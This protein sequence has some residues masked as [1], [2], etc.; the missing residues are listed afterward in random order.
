MKN[1]YFKI[2]VLVLGTLL[3]IFLLWNFKSLLLP[4][5]ESENNNPLDKVNIYF[6]NVG[7]ADSI[8]IESYSGNILIDSG[9]N[10]DGDLLVRRLGD[11]GINKLDYLILTHPHKDHI[12]GAPK[13]LENITVD[14]IIKSDL[15][16]DSKPYNKLEEAILEKDIPNVV[17]KAS[18]K[19][20]LGE[21]EFKILFP[22]KKYYKEEN[23][24]SLVLEMKHGS[25]KFLFTGDI[26]EEGLE[27]L[28]LNKEIANY[29]LLKVPHHGGFEDLTSIFINT[30]KP[31]FAIITNDIEESKNP[32]SE[33]VLQLLKMNNTKTFITGKGE[34]KCISDGENFH[35]SQ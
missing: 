30:I 16:V 2:I 27:E 9:T 21:L 3:C 10:K 34:I 8:L 33:E 23:D 18:D 22:S 14:K 32:I 20:N 4:S 35:I 17:G 11:L 31:K 13:I 5:K 15:I 12:G 1:S 28:L 7:K 19:F 26:E 29:T 6:F 25:N 24:Y